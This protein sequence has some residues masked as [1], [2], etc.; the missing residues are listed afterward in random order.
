MLGRTYKTLYADASY[1]QDTFNSKS[2]LSQHVDPDGVA[3]LYQYNAKGQLVCTA[4][5][6]NLNGVIDFG[7]LDRVTC[8][9]PDVTSDYGAVVQRTQTFVW[10]TLNSN[11]SNLVSKS[12]ISAD[13]LRSWQIS[14]RDP[15][16]PVVTLNQTVY[17]TGG[18]R[19][20]TNVA[21]DGSYIVNAFSYGR[22]A[23]STRFTAS[24]A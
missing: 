23:S 22:L 1:T 7:G 14:Y 24:G 20:Q 17:G 18:N 3:T 10:S 21:P 19:L 8:Q 5:D 16:T 2:Q 6:M 13:G 4:A 9:I 15:N 11:A 12:E